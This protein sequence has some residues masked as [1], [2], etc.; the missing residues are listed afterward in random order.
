M[1]YILLQQNPKDFYKTNLLTRQIRDVPS[2][3]KIT[4]L[5]IVCLRYQERAH[6]FE[7][8]N[9]EIGIEAHGLI[10]GL[11]DDIQDATLHYL[12]SPKGRFSSHIRY[13]AREI[14]WCRVGL[15]LSSGGAKGL[16]HIGIIEILEEH[17]IDVD[18][19]VGASMGAFIGAMW[20]AGLNAK[21]MKAEAMKLK[22]P[23]SMLRLMDPVFLPRQGFMRGEA[24]RRRLNDA[25][26]KVHFSDLTRKLKVITTDLDTLE[27]VIFDSGEAAQTVQASMAMPGVIVPVSLNGRTH[28]DGSIAEPI[29]VQTLKELNVEH[30]PQAAGRKDD[31]RLCC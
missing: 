6:A 3:Q 1:P 30:D 9:K 22:R 5:P 23:W 21:Q 25:I 31:F 19:I 15:A 20:A 26:G 4:L 7:K 17:D 16:A 14:G 13:L 24:V 29:P 18:I 27:R 10:H 28:I 8:I 11:A 12:Q 2:V